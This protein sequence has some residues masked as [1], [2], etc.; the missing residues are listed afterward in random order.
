MIS[1]G[2]AGLLRTLRRRGTGD[3]AQACARVLGADGVVLSMLPAGDRMPEPLW[4]HPELSARFEE[5][6]FTL[7]EGPGPDA[8]RTGAPVVEPDLDRVRSERWPALLPAARELGVHGVCCFPLGIGAI[9]VGVLTVLCDGNR[10]L[11][12]Q[13]YADATALTAALTGAFLNGAPPREGRNGD[14]PGSGG[15]PE[16]PSGLHRAA[17]HQATGMVS[18]QLGVSMDIALLR[19]RA[20]AYASGRPLGEVAQD[21]VARRLRF[22]DDVNG[23][24]SPGGGK[25]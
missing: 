2:M 17:V 14:V 12:E 20:H 13:Q 18:V 5:L 8:V 11:S 3:P 22:D 24:Y 7:G 16:W 25:G 19:L 23:P 21:V 4:C 9:R 1:N 15:F 6:Q 10:R